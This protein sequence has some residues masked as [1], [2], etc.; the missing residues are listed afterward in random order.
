MKFHLAFNSV[1]IVLR[2]S[3][4][5]K[6]SLTFA[7]LLWKQIKQTCKWTRK[8][9]GVKTRHFRELLLEKKQRHRERENEDH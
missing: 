5:R 1:K 7:E 2:I 9:I 3:V 8:K 4:R 6:G